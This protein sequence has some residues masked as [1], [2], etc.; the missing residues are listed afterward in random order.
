MKKSS[1][2]F[3]L[4]FLLIF[5]GLALAQ[6]QAKELNVT[7]DKISYEKGDYLLEATGSVEVIY[8]DIQVQGQHLLYN[9]SAEVIKFDQGFVLQYEG[10]SF[11]GSVLNYKIKSKDGEAEKVAFDYKGL[12]LAGQKIKIEPDYFH[13]NKASF[14][15]C[16][17][18]PPHYKVTAA[19]L[20]L[21]PSHRWLVA[22]W[23]L[24]WLG[25]VPVVPMPTYI[26]DAQ[27]EEKSKRNL[28]P[29]PEIGANQEDG[30][31]ISEKLA[32]HLR[33]EL[34]GSYTLSYA[35]NKG[36][37]GGFEADY[38]VN[39]LN[40]GNFRLYGNPKDGLFG[41]IT[42]DYA[43][44]GDLVSAD[45]SPF[46]FFDL[47][48][49]RQFELETTVAYHERIN[50]QRVSF[51]PD[52]TLSS[53]SGQLGRK[54]AKYDFNLQLGM[55]AEMGNTKLLR[56]GGE[57]LFYGEF[58]ETPIGYITPSL[59]LDNRYY[60]NGTSWIK[61][62][63]GVNLAKRFTSELSLTL[64]YT[65]YWQLSGISPFNYEIYRWRGVD[66]LK[67]GLAFLLGET[68]VKID[69]SYYLDDWSPEDIDYSLLFRLH[70]YNMSVNYRSLRKELM[71]GFSL[72]S[73]T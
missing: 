67:P 66:R 4:L 12:R 13:L 42:H 8:K 20:T 60:S 71:L 23:G 64:D 27:A 21:Y 37:G 38:I 24:F 50:Y 49:Y 28:P 36:V 69:T 68:G 22:Y 3:C 30:T 72:A 62:T 31:Y 54:E 44:G 48:H 55:V 5:F 39:K 6:A 10:L 53:R 32:W 43:F 40:D 70:C 11:E 33:R 17:N 15:T 26:Y 46:N 51:Y 47:P 1:K 57:I 61:N 16:D 58:Q 52:V 29:F 25:G 14:T 2:Y 34:S 9:T 18:L 63:V 65:H 45:K 73:K 59:G 19:D 56:G 7:A 35:A 41:G